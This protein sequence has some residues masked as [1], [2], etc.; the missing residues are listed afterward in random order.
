MKV[1]LAL[2][3]SYPIFFGTWML[4]TST[5]DICIKSGSSLG[6]GSAVGEKSQ[7]TGSKEKSRQAK[8]AECWPGE[9]EKATEPG[10]MPLMPPFHDTR[11]WYRALIGQMP[12]CWQINGAIDGIALFQY[13]APTIQDK[14]FLNMDFEQAIQISL[15][16]FLLIPRLQKRAKNMPVICCKKKKN[17]KYQAFLIH[18][19]Y[20]LWSHFQS[21]IITF[22]P[23]VW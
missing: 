18:S 15:R 20:K 11:F 14:I 10:D 17:S 12:S 1:K 23:K 8:R 19:C 13:H 9:G 21:I 22:L 5:L 7:K 2:S 6:P 3:F 16:D 4:K